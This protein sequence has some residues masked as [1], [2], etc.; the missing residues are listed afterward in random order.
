M[1]ERTTPGADEWDAFVRAHPQAHALQLSA[2]ADHKTHFGWRYVRV[3]LKD[4]ARIA[5]GAQVLIRPLPGKLFTLAYIPHGGYVTDPAQWP[6]LIDAIA[7][8][9][10]PFRAAFIKWEPGLY[11]DGGAPDPAAL[12][13]TESPQTVQPPRTSVLDLI[14]TEDAILARMNQGTRRKIRQS[15]KAGLRVWEASAADVSRFCDLMDAT[16]TRNNFGVHTR[17]YY[18][19]AYDLFAP[20]DCALIL[21]EHE[22]DLLAGVMV[23]AVD[24]APAPTAWYLYGASNDLKRDLMASYGVQWAAMQWAKARGCIRYDLWGL[25]DADEAELEAQFQT[26]SDGLWGVYGFKRGWGGQ[27]VRTLG[28]WDKPLIAPVYWAYQMALKI[29][30]KSSEQQ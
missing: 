13:F 20:R 2:W 4:G 30:S 10:R 25:P 19:L 14:S 29:R 3:A 1:L 27:I 22:G 23:F 18:Q 5:A 8:A 7:Q 12:G 6:Q 26:R 15:L 17:Q 21:A 9:V 24:D 16:G 11:L 28:A